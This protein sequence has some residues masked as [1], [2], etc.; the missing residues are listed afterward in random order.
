MANNMTTTGATGL[1]KLLFQNIDFAGIGDAGGLLQ[2]AVAGDLYISLHTAL[3]TGGDQTSNEAAYDGYARQPVAR[4]NV[5]WTVTDEAVENAAHI[6][7]PE[8]AADPETLTHVGIGTA[9][10]GVGILLFSA[11]L[12]SPLS[13]I[14]GSLPRIPAG[15]LDLAV[16]VND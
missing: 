8:C 15:E 11:A 3:P 13:V 12:S 4:D 9:S 5:E 2:S 10:S 14:V 1:L 16:G 7:F 6:D